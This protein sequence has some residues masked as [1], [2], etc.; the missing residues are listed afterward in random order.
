MKTKIT[1]VALILA[2]LMSSCG[3]LRSNSYYANQ[4]QRWNDYTNGKMK[5]KN[6]ASPVKKFKS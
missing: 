4:G 3:S 1:F 6:N 5:C 2:I